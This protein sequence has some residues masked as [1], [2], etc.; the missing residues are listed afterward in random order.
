M[1]LAYSILLFSFALQAFAYL[2]EY[3]NVFY[4]FNFGIST[5]APAIFGIFQINVITAAVVGGG[6]IAIG[7]GAVLTRS[8]TYA[9]YALL[10]YG[11]GVMVTQV[12]PFILA[13]PNLLKLIPFPNFAG[14]NISMSTPII[15]FVG[16]IIVF[17]WGWFLVELITQRQHT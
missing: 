5:A 4:P 2:G 6:A 17:S 9:L 10:I 16:G 7:I 3:F 8:G 14:T 1:R 15:G 11:I 12:Q 13:I